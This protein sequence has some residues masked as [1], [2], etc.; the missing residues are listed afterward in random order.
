MSKEEPMRTT[1]IAI[2]AALAAGTAFAQAPAEYLKRVADNYRAAFAVYERNGVVTRAQ[3]RGDLFL[4]PRFDDIDIN[5]DG[6]I[7]RAELD[8][9]LA[10]LPAYAT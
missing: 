8:R 2:A 10:S 4:E 9:F 5:R 6:V 3:V 1:I 7:T